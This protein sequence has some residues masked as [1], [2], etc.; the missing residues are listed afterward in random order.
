MA[1]INEPIQKNKIT[2]ENVLDISFVNWLSGIIKKTFKEVLLCLLN[3][4]FLEC[5]FLE[6]IK[7][8]AIKKQEKVVLLEMLS[9][10]GH[11]RIKCCSLR[12]RIILKRKIK[13]RGHKLTS[14]YETSEDVKI[15]RKIYTIIKLKGPK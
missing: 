13:K 11:V 6:Y 10:S 12:G 4:T 3:D 1:D 9:N 5:F 8:K 7:G 2:L 14:W 15:K